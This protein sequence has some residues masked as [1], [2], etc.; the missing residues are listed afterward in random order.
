[1]VNKA[2]DRKLAVKAKAYR[3]SLAVSMLALAVT[4]LG[5]PR[6]W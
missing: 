4:A 2:R 1:V 3:L 6:K 5:A